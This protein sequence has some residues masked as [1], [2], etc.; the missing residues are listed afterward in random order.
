VLPALGATS[1]LTLFE[2]REHNLWV[3]SDTTGLHILRQQK[4][5]T[6]PSLSGHPTTAITQISDGTIWLGSKGGGL[7]RYE[8]GQTRRFLTKDG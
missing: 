1:I 5:R 6:L 4:F 8:G 7:F 3:G 2:D